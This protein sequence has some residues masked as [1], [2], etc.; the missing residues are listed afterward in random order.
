MSNFWGSAPGASF[1]WGGPTL[2]IPGGTAP[3]TYYIGILVDRTN[4][5]AES[6][7]SNNYVSTQI[8]VGP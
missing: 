1:D 7:E 5:V 3:E 2:T 8:T 6:N 4:A